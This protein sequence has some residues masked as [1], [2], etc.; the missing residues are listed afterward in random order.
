MRIN[1][2]KCIK[3]AMKLRGI[4]TKQMAK[5]FGVH[6]QQVDRWKN[7]DDIRISKAMMF[8][9]YFSVH[10]LDFLKLGEES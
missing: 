5:D 10:I 8:A 1:G 6:R 9:E 2:G 7:S 4:T 3:E